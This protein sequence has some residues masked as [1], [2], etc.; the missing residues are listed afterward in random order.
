MSEVDETLTGVGSG[1]GTATS[2]EADVQGH[3]QAVVVVDGDSNSA[4]ID[5]QPKVKAESGDSLG[6]LAIPRNSPGSN[7]PINVP[8]VDASDVVCVSVDFLGGFT[9][10]AVEITNNGG[11]ATDV[12]VKI[13]AGATAD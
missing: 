9:R 13:V 1:G 12:D 6:D 11:T 2:S 4:D 7:P 5:I 10:L 3:R 8:N